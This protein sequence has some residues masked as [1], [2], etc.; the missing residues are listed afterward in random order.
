MGNDTPHG[1]KNAESE[2]PHS[3]PAAL[4]NAGR[5]GEEEFVELADSWNTFDFL[6]VVSDL[7]FTLIGLVIGSVFPMSTLR[8]FRLAKLARVSKVFRVF[9]ERMSDCDFLVWRLIQSSGLEAVL[10]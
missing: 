8:V 10:L 6:I 3:N 2:F 7:F 4:E 1:P 5:L 9:P